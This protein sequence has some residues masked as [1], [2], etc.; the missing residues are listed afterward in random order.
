MS[1]FAVLEWDSAQFGFPVARMSPIGDHQQLSAGLREAR[2]SGIVLAYLMLPSSMDVAA[3]ILEEFGGVSVNGRVTYV[4][5]RHALDHLNTRPHSG[6]RDD[7]YEFSPIDG[8]DVG[9]SLIRLA[10]ESGA[11]SRFRVDPRIDRSVFE[12]IY[13]TWIARSV[14]GEIA[15]SVV[16]ARRDDEIV[17][18]VTLNRLST[19]RG[20][21]GLLAV[22]HRF[23]GRGV[24][25][26]LVSEAAVW[27]RARSLGAV[28][29][30]TQRENGPACALYES[31]GFVVER[32]DHVY[33]FWLSHPQ[34]LPPP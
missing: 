11:F 8:V 27:A 31:M 26:G 15:E 14:R 6:S 22:D 9:Q 4:A 2:H 12:S 18:M 29:V 28:Q 34:V 21:I 25:R 23:R 17:G 5:D 16:V 19:G 10:R 24:G 3:D 7:A 32:S 33:H 13:D 30:V 1:G 20:E